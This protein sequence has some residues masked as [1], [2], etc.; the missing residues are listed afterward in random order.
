MPDVGDTAT[1]TLTV[2]PYDGTTS[3]AVAVTTPTGTTSALSASSADGGATWTAYLPLTEAGAWAV[4]WTVTGQGAGVQ[5]DTVYALAAP[6]LS[7]SY[8]TLG[9]L[10]SYLGEDPPDGAAK[11]LVRAS[12]R[13]DS[14]LIGAVYDVDDDDLPTDADVAAALRDAVC[15][16][17]EWWDE[18]GDTTGTGAGGAWS[19]VTIGKVKLTAGTSASAGTPPGRMRIAPSAI[20]IL[21]T[22][23][24]MPISPYMVG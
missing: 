23:G 8:A 13:V 9:D 24:L 17:V 15:A 12:R 4:V 5:R 11:L 14:A 2:S 19:D 21:Q 10:A 18:V 6:D 22:A 3:T 7:D 16:Q 1:L 20:E